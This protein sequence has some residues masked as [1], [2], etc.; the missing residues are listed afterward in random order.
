MAPQIKYL[1]NPCTWRT[2]KPN[3][4]Y[5][6]TFSYEGG[7]TLY[8]FCPTACGIF[9][10]HVS[11]NLVFF[12]NCLQHAED[13][14]ARMLEFRIE[15]GRG[16]NKSDQHGMEWAKL[17]LSHRDKWLITEAPTN[18]FFSVGWADNDTIL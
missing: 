14:L 2:G 7:T 5:E 8:H 1:S 18:Q 4:G 12:A 10:G 3:R 9:H 11:V 16:L 13:V 17:I 6:A 15:C